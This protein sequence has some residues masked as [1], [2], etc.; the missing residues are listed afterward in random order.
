MEVL[1]PDRVLARLRAA[2]ARVTTE[3]GVP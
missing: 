2:L 1:G 3:T